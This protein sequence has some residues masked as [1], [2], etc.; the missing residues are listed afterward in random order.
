[1]DKSEIKWILD[2]AEQGD[3]QAQCIL[4]E[5]YYTGQGVEQSD[6]KAVEWFQKAAEQGYAQ[7]QYNLGFSY[8]WGKGVE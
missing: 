6:K 2:A 7:A 5:H 1:M 8:A 4:G 3:I